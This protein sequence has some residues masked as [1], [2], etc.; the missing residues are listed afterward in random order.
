M[1][2]Q[3]KNWV[4]GNKNSGSGGVCNKLM[5]KIILLRNGKKGS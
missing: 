3:L 5:G 2:I 1:Y 4:E